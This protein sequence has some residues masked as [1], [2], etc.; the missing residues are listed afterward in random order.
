M[1]PTP[2][3]AE[4]QSDQPTKNPTRRR[5]SKVMDD[6]VSDI[7]SIGSVNSDDVDN[8]LSQGDEDL[9][10]LD[11]KDN[12]VILANSQCNV[13]RDVIL[14]CEFSGE[15]PCPSLPP[16]SEKLAM[17]VTTWMCNTPKREK[18]CEMFREALVPENV[19]GVLPVRINEIL[20]Q[21]LPFKAHVNNQRLRG[22]NTYFARGLAPLVSVLDEIVKFESK[23]TGEE[24]C[25]KVFTGK[26]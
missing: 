11:G 3:L 15:E 1:V 13:S 18:I 10:D 4:Q 22:I 16:V 8:L 12:E 17:A 25:W 21:C 7:T 14:A 19:E 6:E 23:L 26:N 20:Y 5:R 24:G 2:A 9:E